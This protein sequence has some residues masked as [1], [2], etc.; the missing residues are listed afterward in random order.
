VARKAHAVKSRMNNQSAENEKKDATSLPKSAD[1]K[2][3]NKNVA[4]K[5]VAEIGKLSRQNNRNGTV[6]KAAVRRA[7]K[8]KEM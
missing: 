7:N 1:T 6:N 2:K 4:P 8:D 3:A 5:I